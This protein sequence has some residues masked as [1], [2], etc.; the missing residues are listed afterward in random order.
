MAGGNVGRVEPNPPPRGDSTAGAAGETGSA[1]GIDAGEA[2][3]RGATLMR[4]E[5]G[6]VEIR[7]EAGRARLRG[8][9]W[10]IVRGAGGVW[11]TN[12]ILVTLALKLSALVLASGA[13]CT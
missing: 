8:V 11:L 1:A 4:A 13:D 7:A 2:T 5:A 3:G 6:A 12:C 9:G 10:L